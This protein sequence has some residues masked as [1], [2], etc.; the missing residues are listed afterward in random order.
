MVVIFKNECENY[1]LLRTEMSINKLNLKDFF[2]NLILVE[3]IVDMVIGTHA[4][5]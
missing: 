2:S 3:N 4:Q 1:L 5:F